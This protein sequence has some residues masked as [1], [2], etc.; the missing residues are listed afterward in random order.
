MNVVSQKKIRGRYWLLGGLVLL[1]GIILLV[2]LNATRSPGGSTYQTEPVTRGNLTTS[3]G[4]TGSVR[5]AQS[6]TLVWKTGG[7]VES[8]KAA[9]GARVN[10]DQELAALAPGSV[11]QNVI[12]AESDLVTAQQNLDTL[13]QST[14]GMAQ[15][16]KNLADAGQAVEDAQIKLDFYVYTSKGRVPEEILQDYR[17]QIKQSKNQLKMMDWI[18]NRF[19]KN[20]GDDLRRKANFNISLTN[21]QQNLIDLTT[22]YNWY[23]GKPSEILMEQTRA[24]L[25]LAQAKLEDA[26]RE[27]DRISKDNNAANITAA[28]AKVAAAQATFNQSKIIAPFNGTITQAKLQAGDRV[29][30]GDIAFRIDDLSQLMV[31]LEISEVDINNVALGQPVTISFD[32]IPE[33]VYKGTIS[34]V[35]LAAKAGEGAVNFTVTVSLNDADE[36]VKPGMSAQV[37]ITVKEVSDTLVIPNRAL[38]MLDGQRIVY[39]LKDNQPVAVNIR[40]GATA[41][42]N[43]QVVGGDLKEGDLLILNP[44]AS[45][46]STPVQPT[47]TPQK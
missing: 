46:N 16:M 12:L 34:K 27:M 8:V 30:S 29:S 17:D 22:K 38:R 39:V 5:A 35:N 11:S 13:L 4:A 37:T 6:V 7:R 36:L 42:A 2:W 31:D 32:A 9:I 1:A 24:A 23:T 21:S 25:N 10:A 20:T 14:N 19:Y 40:L 33:K 15:A 41:D 18:L 3:V 43:S 44:P 47:A 26:Q 28:K 45:I